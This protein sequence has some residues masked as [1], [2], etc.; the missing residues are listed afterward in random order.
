VTAGFDPLCDE[1]VAYADRLATLG[2]STNHLHYPGE[3]HAFFSLPHLVADARSAHAA[4]AQALADAF[5]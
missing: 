5:A 2:V 4:A 3:I 1:G